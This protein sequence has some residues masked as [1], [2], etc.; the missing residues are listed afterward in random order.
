MAGA[1]HNPNIDVPVTLAPAARQVAGFGAT[2]LLVPLSANSLG[3]VRMLTLT[4]YEDAQDARTAGTISAAT[5]SACQV[6]FAQRPKTSVFKLGYVDLTLVKAEK[7][8]GTVGGGDF[9]TVI[10]ATTGGQD[11]NLLSVALTAGG[12]LGIV[13]TGD[14]VVIT[15][16]AATTTVAQVEAAITALSGAS[17]IIAVKTAGTGATVLGAPDAFAATLLAGGSGET[18]SNALTACVA[19]DGDFYGVC[20]DSRSGAVIEALAAT[21][22]ASSE[23]RLFAFQSSDADWLTAGL[24][25]AFT[26]VAGLERPQG[27]YHTTDAEWLD[28][29]C[30]VGRLTAD[31]DKTSTPWNGYEVVGVAAYTTAPTAAQRLIAIAN[32]INLMLPFGAATKVIDPGVSCAG[33]PVYEQL[34]ADWFFTRVREDVALLVTTLANRQEKLPITTTGQSKVKAVVQARYDQAVAVGHLVQPDEDD[35]PISLPAITNA[36]RTARLISVTVRGQVSVSARK[37]SIPTYFST[38]ALSA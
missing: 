29:A 17:D 18:Y 19:F 10:E 37:F 15:Y 31:P 23:K 38:D 25:T 5:L 26:D 8:F 22:E 12:A 1:T 14:A 21:I 11:G 9:D 13:V 20:I 36:D 6:A 3:G 33:R 28:V 4:N 7:D 34:S 2:L 35:E 27:Y 30:M 24:P 32:N 16:I